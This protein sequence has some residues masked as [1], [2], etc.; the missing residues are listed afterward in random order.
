MK[1]FDLND[2]APKSVAEFIFHS[3]VSRES[4]MSIV[5]GRKAFPAF[6]K[7][8]ILLYGTYGTGKS[9][10]ARM[11]PAAIERAISGD[12]LQTYDYFDCMQ[13]LTGPDLMR[14]IG[15]QVCL[16]SLH[17]SD[18]HYFVLDEVDNLTDG[19]QASLKTAMNAPLGIFVL[20]TNNIDKVDRG[21]RDRCLRVNC[22]AA[23]SEAWLPFARRILSDSGINTVTDADLL[24]Y[25][26][27]C[28]GSLREI[29]DGVLTVAAIEAAK[30]TATAAPP[31]LVV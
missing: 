5:E 11:L 19:A 8:G 30:Q 13:G 22:N 15:S 17:A 4:I 28:N 25:I 7:N 6:G 12:D 16:V 21:V 3:D 24:R 20:T 27:G 29:A 31:P 18:K 9:T 23:P 14:K 2:Y 1:N 26:D 10:L